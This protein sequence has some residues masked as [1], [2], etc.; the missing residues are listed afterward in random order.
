M[1]LKGATERVDLKKEKLKEEL[2]KPEE[3]QNREKVKRL[4]E[5]IKRHKNIGKQIKDKRYKS[6]R[7]HGQRINR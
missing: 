1:N 6:K 2:S 5:S 3:E 7:K 4:Q